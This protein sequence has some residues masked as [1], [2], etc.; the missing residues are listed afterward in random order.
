MAIVLC[1]SI[2]GSATG[3]DRVQTPVT[4]EQAAEAVLAALRAKDQP[5]LKALAERD[6][7]DPWLVA[8]ELCAREEYDAAEAFAK[9]APRP[10]TEKLPGY[11][12]AHQVSPT[13]P[14]VR[15][16]V[17][18]AQQALAKG[19]AKTALSIAQ[20]VSATA[21][22]SRV[23][24]LWY[25][26]RA[27]SELGSLEAVDAFYDAADVAE[28]LGWVAGLAN[29]LDHAG[30]ELWRHGQR[31]G[32]AEAWAWRLSV[33]ETRGN[34][35]ALAATLRSLGHAHISQIA[36]RAEWG[37]AGFDPDRALELYRRALR[38]YEELHDRTGVIGVLGDIAAAHATRG[39]ETNQLVFLEKE[40]A[41]REASDDASG[42]AE[43]LAKIGKLRLSRREYA[44]S[45][46]CFERALALTENVNDPKRMFKALWNLAEAHLRLGNH[47][48]AIEYQERCIKL[49]EFLG[50]RWVARFLLFL[51]DTRYRRAGD[52]HGA[53]AAFEEAFR[54]NERLRNWLSAAT[55]LSRIGQL[56]W[57]SE[58]HAGALRIYT[59][60]LEFCEKS[61]KGEQSAAWALVQIGG[62]E[63]T[64][65]SYAAALASWE[66]ALNLFEKARNRQGI[67]NVNLNIGLVYHETGEFERA[68]RHLKLALD[69]GG[70]V[71]RCLSAIANAQRRLGNAHEAR[72]QYEEALSIARKSKYDK[73]LVGRIL[74][75]IGLLHQELGDYSAALASHREALKVAEEVGSGYLLADVLIAT[76]RACRLLRDYVR[77][78]QLAERGLAIAR[79]VRNAHC[80]TSALEELAATHLAAGRPERAL[81]AAHLAVERMS[82]LVQ[83]LADEQGA[84][85]RERFSTLF[86]SGMRAGLAVGD[87][88]EVGFFLESGRAGALRE[89]LALSE[90]LGAVVLPADL[91]AAEVAARDRER[92]AQ[93]HYD[94]AWTNGD[95]V[96]DPVKQLEA[97]QAGVVEVIQRI[98]REAKA[99][100]ALVYPK[101]DSLEDIQSALRADEAL[102]L[103]ALMEKESVALVV[104]PAKARIV[105][106]GETEKIAPAAEAFRRA[107]ARPDERGVA[108][109]PHESFD[110]LAKRL[111]KLVVEP[112][113]LGKDVR[114]L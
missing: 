81:E 71:A 82:A 89:G 70:P 59:K 91:R 2:A 26:G 54:I 68:L 107:V 92:V 78:V 105:P 69:L 67:E 84:K 93:W 14:T 9:A 111:R 27:L 50:E 112:L 80:E 106:L 103:Y 76:S 43:T 52:R 51:G 72:K 17:V 41:L 83:G 96:S 66:R 30:R 77:A 101:A 38:I 6:A 3:Q 90:R 85:M 33:E 53:L 62:A 39:D 32:A 97:A 1:L 99:Q 75:N 37:G 86:E 12:A 104:T 16:T 110:Y 47:A 28:E 24:L 5:A 100:A 7:P 44:S 46:R 15:K 87:V 45:L 11:V 57:W 102:V 35:A 108:V 114:R 49:R 25:R 61:E 65:G 55:A 94:R 113:G 22:L 74:N 63:Y 34:Q 98:Q 29:A 109:P 42:A 18:A 95:D 88:D 23:R 64:M 21:G 60:Q 4:P 10:D 56:Y 73:R 20:E 36:S 31:A 79:E 58:D 40:L 8:D 19:D 48:K 13:D